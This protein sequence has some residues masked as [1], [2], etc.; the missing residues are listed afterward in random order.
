MKNLF[1]FLSIIFITSTCSP[2]SVIITEPE[3]KVIY[4]TISI[5][6]TIKITKYQEIKIYDTVRVSQIVYDTIT[7]P[8]YEYITSEVYEYIQE[9]VY[10]TVFVEDLYCN[11]QGLICRLL[12]GK[13]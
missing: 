5:Y 8:T 12:C 11:K 9:T 10:D 6:D 7:I 3:R 13:R 4:D 2:E 1:Y